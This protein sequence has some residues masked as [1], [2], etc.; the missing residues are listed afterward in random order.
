MIRNRDARARGPARHASAGQARPRAFSARAV[1]LAVLVFTLVFGAVI[2]AKLGQERQRAELD[3]QGAHARTA[4]VFAEDVEGRIAEVRGALAG[5]TA[6][7]SALSQ[8]SLETAAGRAVEAL[9]A[10]PQVSGAGLLLPDGRVIAAGA[11]DETALRAAADLALT[12]DAGIAALPGMETPLIAVR[13]AP[14]ADGSV[15]ALVAVLAPGPLLGPRRPGEIAIL[16]TADGRVLATAPQIR[17]SGAPRIADLVGLD[18][19][20]VADLARRGGA[21]PGVDFA[22]AS[23]VLGAAP[24]DAAPLTAMSIGPSGRRWRW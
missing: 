12:Q 6:Q 18:P 11:H 21:A 24:V 10:L 20:R 17:F 19:N 3:A 1:I 22:G 14:L 8:P 23:G 2:V 9:S 5:A 13:P 4:A 16:T 15:G 7:L